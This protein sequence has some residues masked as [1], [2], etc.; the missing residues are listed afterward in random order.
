[1]G[2]HLVGSHPALLHQRHH[3]TH[4]AGTR[5]AADDLE[6]VQD[7]LLHRYLDAHGRDS[8]GRAPPA[9]A[10]HAERPL[11]RHRHAG[12][13]EDYVDTQAAGHG[14]NRLNRI[15]RARID[16]LEAEFRRLRPT[17]RVGLD[18]DDSGGAADERRVS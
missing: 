4:L 3:P 18:H 16:R 5:A 13:L 9:A 14:A 1:M 10:K 7:E 6:F 11:H 17:T 12:A 2:D 8:H 15:C